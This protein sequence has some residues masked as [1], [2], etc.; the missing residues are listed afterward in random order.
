MATLLILGSKPD[1]ILPLAS[2][3]DAVACANGSGFSAAQ[4]GLPDPLFTAVSAVLTIGIGSGR[5]SMKAMS[6]LHTGTLYFVPRTSFRA[7]FIKNIPIIHQHIRATPA[8]FRHALRRAGF[9]WDRF[10]RRPF[11]RYLDAIPDACRNDHDVAQQLKRKRPSTGLVALLI[12]ISLNRFDRFVI[13]GFSFELTHAYGDNPEISE[14]GTVTSRHVDTDILLLRC[15]SKTL[16]I[17]YTTE[18]T[19]NEQA[20]VPLL[21]SRS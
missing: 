20:Q 5:Q 2:A 6:G 3:Y 8:W 7:N 12:G 14:R 10:E 16:G 9:R 13:S 17:I 1:P 4:H 19:V 11:N 21:S 18:P 15:L